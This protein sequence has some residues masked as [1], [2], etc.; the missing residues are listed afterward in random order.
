[1]LLNDSASTCKRTATSSPTVLSWCAQRTALNRCPSLI[2][3]RHC[4]CCA[5]LDDD[6]DGL[7]TTTNLA[8][9]LTVLNH[10]D[11]PTAQD[12]DEVVD[13]LNKCRESQ[14]A[15]HVQIVRVSSEPRP[16]LAV[17]ASRA[18]ARVASSGCRASVFDV[19]SAV[20]S[21]QNEETTEL[22][23]ENADFLLVTFDYYSAMGPL[24][25]RAIW[26]DLLL[27]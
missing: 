23:I 20:L 11:E 4:V 18:R 6:S 19:L 26:I 12:M 25:M 22:Q 8:K 27:T 13:N 3:D 9:W 7:L 10:G 17:P 16:P 24:Y 1:M 15:P 14:G 21:G 5:K 2:A